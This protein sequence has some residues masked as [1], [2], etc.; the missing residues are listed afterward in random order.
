MK[1]LEYLDSGHYQTEEVIE[2]VKKRHIP[3]YE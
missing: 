1:L 3:G 2:L